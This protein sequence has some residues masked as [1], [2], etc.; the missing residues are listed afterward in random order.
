[1]S[2]QVVRGEK[3][4]QIPVTLAERPSESAIA[5]AR[6]EPAPEIPGLVMRPA[7]PKRTEALGV[8][9]GVEVV[10]VAKSS[11]A[12]G[13]LEPG[14]VIVEVDHWPVRDP[15]QVTGLVAR[16]RGAALLQVHGKDG[17]RY[18]ALELD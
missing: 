16:A 14:D 10:S 6:S 9:A 3:Q 2:L 5:T 4:M 18:V 17:A 13:V 15:S 8:P 11:P 7:S 12:H 1:V